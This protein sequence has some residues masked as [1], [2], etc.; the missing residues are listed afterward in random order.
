MN[1]CILHKVLRLFFITALLLG[2][3]GCTESADRV[4]LSRVQD[5]EKVPAGKGHDLYLLIG[6]SNMAGRG[7]IEDEDVRPHPRVLKLN[8][9]NEWIPARDP[10]HFDKK[11]AGVGPGRTFGIVLADQNPSR[12]IGLVPCAVGGTSIR[13]WQPGAYDERTDTYPYDDMLKRMRIAMQSGTLKG[14]LWHQGESDSAM[15]LDGTYQEKLIQLVGRLR[16]DLDAE[17][18]PFVLGQMGEFEGRPWDAG[19]KKVDLVHKLLCGEVYNTGFVSTKGFTDKGDKVHFDAPS[20]RELGRRFAWKMLELQRKTN[21]FSFKQ[22]EQMLWPKGAP[23]AKDI[24]DTEYYENGRILKVHISTLTTFYPPVEVANDSAVIICPG[25]GYRSL[26]ID[27][28]GYEIARWLNSLGVTAFVLKYRLTR[29]DGTGYQ[30]PAQ[31][32]DLKR[33]IRI[34]R[35]NAKALNIDPEKIGAIGFSAGGHLVSTLGTHFDKGRKDAIDFVEQVSSRP[36]F[37]MLI[38]PHISLTDTGTHP[39]YVSNLLG[40]DY[41]PKL[42]EFLSNEKQVTGQTP[43]AFLVHARDDNIVPF[44]HSVDFYMAMQR[45]GV[46]GQLHIFE[47]GGHGFGLGKATGPVKSWPDLCKDW[48]AEVAQDSE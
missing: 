35:S 26:S 38:Y 2:C 7:V 48:I 41:E 19:R 42:A 22:T 10:I 23:D 40:D 25:G 18:I 1:G 20:A 16:K 11:I 14:I 28:E 34:V 29:P 12:T 6:Q 4:K 8:R 45:A 13:F 30:Y 31:L 17:R 32:N 37:M 44:E 24:P 3:V 43:Q 9:E 47:K 5:A 15:G 21:I 33:A 36:D 46:G 27:K 39:S